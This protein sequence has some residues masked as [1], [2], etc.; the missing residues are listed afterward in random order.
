M[1]HVPRTVHK[2]HDGTY[3]LHHDCFTIVGIVFYDVIHII[4]GFPMSE[5]LGS[6]HF[7]L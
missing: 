6:T 4:R 1:T 5:L 3:D 2:L 7:I